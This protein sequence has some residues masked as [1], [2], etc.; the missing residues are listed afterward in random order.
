MN[1]TFRPLENSSH[2]FK[3]LHKWC[4]QEFVY[5][6]FEQRIL[7]YDE[8]VT[9]YTNK[10]NSN[11]QELLIIKCDD[12]DIGF[13]Q[14]YKYNHDV[15]IKN[16]NNY[17]NIYEFDLFIGEEAYLS[18]GIGT[19]IVKLI[20]DMI[21]FKYHADVI[22]L[23]PFKRNIRAIKCYEKCDYKVIDE[24]NGKDTLNNPEIITVLLNKNTNN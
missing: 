23:R 4:K 1:I 21:Y 8:I 6:W 24:Y 17:N 11:K 20:N 2:D 3:L 13:T 18:K 5:T 16:I 12:K 10:L 7:S 22:I 19:I 15:F 9:K 14:I